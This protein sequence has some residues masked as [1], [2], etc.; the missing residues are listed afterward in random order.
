MSLH[1]WAENDHCRY[2]GQFYMSLRRVDPCPVRR[3]RERMPLGLFSSLTEQQK[4]KVIAYRGPE[5]H[6]DPS[7]ALGNPK[8]TGGKG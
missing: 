5:N 8:P 3:Q 7:Y 1:S 4:A 6:G 2:C